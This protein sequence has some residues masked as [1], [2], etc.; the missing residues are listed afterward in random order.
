MAEEPGFAVI[1]SGYYS[2][3]VDEWRRSRSASRSELPELSAG[4][5]EF[6]RRFGVSEEEYARHRLS[7]LYGRE[8]IVR[9]AY[10]LGRV[11]VE[12]I[13]S[14]SGE[15]FRLLAVKADLSQGPKALRI[16][17]PN[18]VA[19]VPVPQE[20]ADAIVGRGT[21]Q[22]KASLKDL[23]LQGIAQPELAVKH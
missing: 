10:E 4:D 22:D 7:G 20:L 1:V 14:G 18:W 16:Q 21:V 3:T 15:G 11:V 9:R 2:C 8:R 19:D 17:T 13:L 6:A 23:V 12:E 5:K